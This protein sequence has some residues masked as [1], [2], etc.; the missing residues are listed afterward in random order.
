MS[1]VNLNVFSVSTLGEPR[2]SP[3]GRIP[4]H[5]SDSHWTSVSGNTRSLQRYH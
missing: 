5:E 4:H 2:E 1:F 3:R